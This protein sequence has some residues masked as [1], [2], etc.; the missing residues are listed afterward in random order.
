MMNLRSFDASKSQAEPAS[1]FKKFGYLIILIDLWS[2][3]TKK[4]VNYV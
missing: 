2:A 4:K 1:F 3:D